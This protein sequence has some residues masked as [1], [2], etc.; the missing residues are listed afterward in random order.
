MNEFKLRFVHPRAF[1]KIHPLGI[2]PLLAVTKKSAKLLKFN[3]RY[4]QS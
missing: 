2:F 1:E 3:H 4:Y